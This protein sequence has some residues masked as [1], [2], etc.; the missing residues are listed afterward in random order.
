MQQGN[1]QEERKA[2]LATEDGDTHRKTADRW[3]R[4]QGK[5]WLGL[6]GW[7]G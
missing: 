1:F 5:S 6:G 3:R 4:W 2:V 7:G